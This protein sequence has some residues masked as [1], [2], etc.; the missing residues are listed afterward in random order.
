MSS[1][2]IQLSSILTNGIHIWFVETKV[3]RPDQFPPALDK[4]VTQMNL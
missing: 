4:Y 2:N 3:T 1:I